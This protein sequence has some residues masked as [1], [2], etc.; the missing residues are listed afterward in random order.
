M[1]TTYRRWERAKRANPTQATPASL[2][3][4][5]TPRGQRTSGL[6]SVQQAP[7][8]S[9]GR[10][11]RGSIPRRC[12]WCAVIRSIPRLWRRTEP[13]GPLPGVKGTVWERYMLVAVQWPTSADPPGPDNDGA[14]FPGRPDARGAQHES[15]K[16]TAKAQENLINTTMETYLQDRPSSCMACHQVVSN[17]R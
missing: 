6:R 2:T 14:F 5:S 15:Y 8:R 3:P 11:R 4:I 7:C 16:S 9:I 10:T 12:R 17:A 13:I 1:S